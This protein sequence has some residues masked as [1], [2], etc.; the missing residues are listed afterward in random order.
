[1][2]LGLLPSVGSAL[3]I[4]P[5][6]DATTLTTARVSGQGITV[7]ESKYSGAAV[8]AGTYT[9][10]PLKIEDGI[11]VTTGSAKLAL[12]PN[13]EEGAGVGHALGG[14]PLCKLLAPQHEMKDAARLSVKFTLAPGSGGVRFAFLVGSEE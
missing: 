4:K 9:Q 5:T 13:N 12:P 8:A 11:L 10:G 2:T 7:T 6:N 3:D 1:M 14:D